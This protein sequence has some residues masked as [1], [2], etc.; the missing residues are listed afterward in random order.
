MSDARSSIARSW[1]DPSSA[2]AVF[3]FLLPW[4]SLLLLRDNFEWVLS[5]GQIVAVGFLFWWMS[6]S[7]A[8]PI[9]QVKRPMLESFFAIALIVLW[10][11]WRAGICSKA[12]PFLPAQFNCYENYEFE[13]IP[14]LV[15]TTIFPF[16]VLLL[17]GYGLSAQGVSWIWR[18]WWIALPALI[19]AAG[20]GFY[21]HWVKP[22]EFITNTG[23]FFLDAG[24]PE[25]YVFRALLLT[26]LEA[27]FRRPGWALFGASAIFGLSHLAIDYLVFTK[28][29]WREAWVTLLTFQMGF[30]FA[31]AFAYQ[32]VRNIW[33]VALLHA[34]VDAL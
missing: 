7:G 3:L 2:P 28:Q 27:W 6:R 29:D 22:S 12:F 31:F 23:T 4:A 14:K 20:Y 9:P 33:P 26:R 30:G 10:V 15:D 32:R 34:M 1:H 18:A 16:I 13:T 17:A 5:L 25:E 24:L 21:L 19:A 8:A 11:E